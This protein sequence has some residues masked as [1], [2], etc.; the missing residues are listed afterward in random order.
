MEL[1]I[2]SS[3]RYVYSMEEISYFTRPKATSLTVNNTST[4][5]TSCPGYM[6]VYSCI[7][8][9]MSVIKANEAYSCKSDKVSILY[10]IKVRIT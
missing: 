6:G 1:V 7:M 5:L 4:Y 2:L 3:T 9:F 8:N 10:V